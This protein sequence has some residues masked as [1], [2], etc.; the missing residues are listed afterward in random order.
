ML[1]ISVVH[2]G[3][4]PFLPVFDAWRFLYIKKAGLVPIDFAKKNILKRRRREEDRDSVQLQASKKERK[5]TTV[6][7]MT[8]L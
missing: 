6:V 2:H 7:R 3:H 8:D 1:I 5:L 4:S